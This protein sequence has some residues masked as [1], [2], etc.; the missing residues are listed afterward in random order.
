MMALLAL[1][2]PG[3]QTLWRSAFAGLAVSA[4]VLLGWVTVRETTQVRASWLAVA[5]TISAGC[6]YGAVAVVAIGPGLIADI[7]IRL[8]A[9]QVEEILLSVLVFIAV[10][11]AWYLM[12]DEADPDRIGSKILGRRQQDF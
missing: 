2:E 9:L 11:V 8:R 6:L 12:F 1:V 4:A 5:W 10:N 3:N 7:G